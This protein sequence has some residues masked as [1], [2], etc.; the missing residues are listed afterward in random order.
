VD[1]VA[2][3]RD[4]ISHYAPVLIAPL[5]IQIRR[6]GVQK[7]FDA[8]LAGGFS[9]QV[10]R[11]LGPV[12]VER[13]VKTIAVFDDFCHANDPYEEHDFGSCVDGA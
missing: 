2:L 8:R 9:R 3:I 10:W 7:K 5:S 13:I 4:A 6:V 1:G 12:A 11:P